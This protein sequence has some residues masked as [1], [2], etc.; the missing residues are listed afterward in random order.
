MT[1]P[2]RLLTSSEDTFELKVL[3]TAEL[4]EPSAAAVRRTLQALAVGTAAVATWTSTAAAGA[5]AAPATAT[6]L[7]APAGGWLVVKYLGLGLVVGAVT[8]AGAYGV[9]E[10]AERGP[11]PT[12][13]SA[14]L[15]SAERAREAWVAPLSSVAHPRPSA[16]ARTDAP[17]HAAFESPP[18]PE[19]GT[20]RGPPPV[21]E[22]PTAPL[23]AQRQSSLAEEVSMLD[24]A[25]SYLE[26]RNGAAVLAELD[27]Y[28]AARSSHLLQTEATVLRIEALLQLGNRPEARRLAR[29]VLAQ[30]PPHRLAERLYAI[31]QGETK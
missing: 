14:P 7:L 21:A 30:H 20:V 25:R 15:P 5:S 28:Q 13:H 26:Q 17:S 23:A 12:E 9:S 16:A 27:R 19:P 22:F 6:A 10:M 8:T 18:A 1:F 31:V 4:D 3:R 2:E 29:L 24:R 11:I